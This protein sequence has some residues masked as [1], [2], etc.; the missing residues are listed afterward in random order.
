MPDTV[1][2]VLL[3]RIIRL[4]ATAKRLLQTAAVI[5]KDVSLPLLHAVTEVPEEAMQRDLGHLQAAEF[6]YETYAP[7]ALAYTFKHTLTQEV[8]SQSLVR[9][10]RQRYHERI[11]QVLEE[12][13]PEVA[14]TQPELLAQHYTGAERGAQAIAYWQRAGQRAVERSANVEAISHFTKGLELLKLLPETP[15]RIQQ[16][17]ML[18]LALGSPLLI[19]KGQAAP[20]VEQLYTR[21]LEL[22]QW[23]GDHAQHFAAL[24]GLIRFNNSAGRFRTACEVAEQGIALA[25]RVCDPALRWEAH[26]ELGATLFYLG[27]LVSA[28]LHLEQGLALYAPEQNHFQVFSSGSPAALGPFSCGMD[29]LAARISRSRLDQESGGVGP[30]PAVVASLHLGACPALCGE[31]PS[32]SS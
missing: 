23:V 12:R 19:I 22:G 9:H 25:Q 29:P 28:R 5:G 11:A 27:D 15:E 2:A 7:T 6:L 18:H 24:K 1:Q 8:T 32:I 26:L 10:V 30:G 16:E 31:C 3:A 21:A 14:E 4:P 20:E 13:F 17:L